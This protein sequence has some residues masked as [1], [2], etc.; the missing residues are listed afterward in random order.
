MDDIFRKIDE[1]AKKYQVS[2]WQGTFRDYLSLVIKHPKLAQLAHARI[3]DM[4]RSYGVDTDEH[5]NEHF[6]FFARELF[7]IDEALAK[8]VE[9]LKAAAVGSDV[10]KRI[11]ML[12]G[13][14][15]SGKSQLVILLKRGLEE[16]THS[17]D[18]AVYAIADCPQHENPLHL[19]PHALRKDF[20]DDY[21]TYVEGEL[22]PMCSLSMREKYDNDIYRVPVKRIFLSEKERIGI[23]TFVPSDPK[24]QDIS[25]LVG[26]IDLAT[27]GEYGSESD[28]R[29]YRFDGELNIANRGMIEFIEMLK[30]DERFLYILLTLTQEKNIKTGRFPLIYA[31]EFVIAHTNEAEFKEFL[32]DKKSEALQDRMIMV[33]MPY[34]LKVSA[35]IRIY[36]KLLRQANIG[37]LHIAP[38][39]L[40][41]AA[42]F[43]VLSRLEEPKMAGMTLIKKMRLYDG[44]EVEGFRQK[45]VKLVKAQ[46]DREGMDGISPR[47]VINRISSS[48]IRPNTK[49][50]NPID[51]LRA[52]KDGFDTHGAFKREDREKFDNL[53]AD[54]R[55][56][57]DEIAKTDVQKAFFV[58]FE[59]EA[60][61]LLDNYL[62]NVE[63]YLD[64]KKIVDPLTEEEREPD[65]KLMRS[66]E[67]KVK[68][69]ESGK[70]A[71]RN[72]IFRKVAMAQRRGERFDY[73][74][75]EKLKEAIEKQLFEER[76]DTIK[77]TVSTRNPDPDQLR[78]VNEVVDTLVRKETY[79]AECANELLKYVSSLLAREK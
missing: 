79:C 31:D 29:A 63:A 66:I 32:A 7:G 26:S 11:L 64:D 48:L 73:T 41:V 40:E 43:A 20:L 78:K 53:I 19:I 65:E 54:V 62:D 74:T 69:P 36:E 59:R 77:L 60:L 57:Y 35:E 72:E 21:D 12:Y 45:D 3:Y 51:V 8:V 33:Q 44:Q 58:S 71:F 1:H 37:T 23:G 17:D 13:P 75:H 25:E 49:C 55:R 15:S 2:H 10:G 18:G 47:F 24:S 56:E 67:E 34:N 5:G 14:P 76:R 9:Y 61:T 42:M 4:V 16:Y 50:I 22:C 30:A 39:A 46:T 70:D 28:P 68:V 52:I 27:V 6:T 38:H